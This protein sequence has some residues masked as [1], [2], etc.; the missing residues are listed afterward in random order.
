LN[1][2]SRKRAVAIKIIER[3]KGPKDFIQKF[4]PR[5][6]KIHPK[7]NHPNII[8]IY[9]IM[10]IPKRCYMFMEYADGGDL[11]N[12]IK[13]LRSSSNFKKIF[14]KNIFNSYKTRNEGIFHALKRKKCFINYVTQL[15]IYMIKI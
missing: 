8:K 9:Q 14:E 1:K 2:N 6:L 15:N 7:L 5:E 11:L 3:K 13:V 4:L 10:M 12:Y